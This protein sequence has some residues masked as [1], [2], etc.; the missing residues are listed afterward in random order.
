M[1]SGKSGVDTHAQTSNSKVPHSPMNKVSLQRAK[2]W[3]MSLQSQVSPKSSCLVHHILANKTHSAR[4]GK[5][6]A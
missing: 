1:A 6:A 2:L 4:A 5:Q 3:L